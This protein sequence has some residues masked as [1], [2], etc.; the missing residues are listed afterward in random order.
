MMCLFY[1]VVLLIWVTLSVNQRSLWRLRSVLCTCA[2]PTSVL[3][4]WQWLGLK[5]EK[6]WA[7]GSS[8]LP[9]AWTLMD[10][11]PCFLSLNSFPP[12]VTQGL[13]SSVRWCI[14]LRSGPEMRGPLFC[15]SWRKTTHLY[16]DPTNVVL[17][18]EVLDRTVSFY[19][20]NFWWM[21]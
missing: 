5:M 20:Q 15:Q 13:S 11:T 7:Q 1:Q 17:C 18:E 14:A 8:T 6:M 12:R 3:R 19:L 16:S 9:R 4:T 2:L 21:V 10:A